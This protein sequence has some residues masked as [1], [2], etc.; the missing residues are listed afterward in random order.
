MWSLGAAYSRPLLGNIVNRSLIS[1]GLEGCFNSGA[2]LF[3][4]GEAVYELQTGDNM[5]L[6]LLSEY[7]KLLPYHIAIHITKH[8]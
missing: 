6:I 1:I 7:I 3:K 2:I 8:V 4:D 5:I